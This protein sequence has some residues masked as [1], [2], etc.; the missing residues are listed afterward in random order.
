MLPGKRDSECQTH[1]Q[2]IP[3]KTQQ[4]CTEQK[5]VGTQTEYCGKDAEVQ[6]D[7]HPRTASRSSTP[8]PFDIDDCFIEEE[9]DRDK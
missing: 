2:A 1:V 9:P 6:A 7:V 8:V 5:T 4:A 3:T